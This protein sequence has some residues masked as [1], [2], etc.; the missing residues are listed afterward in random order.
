MGLRMNTTSQKSINGQTDSAE[1]QIHPK[2]TELNKML[3]KSASMSQIMAL[4]AFFSITTNNRLLL[5]ANAIDWT[6]FEKH[7]SKHYSEGV[8][9]NNLP[10]RLMVGLHILKYL[11]DL[12]DERVVQAWKEN[13]AYRLFTGWEGESTNN[14]PCDPSSLCKFRKRMGYEGMH[15]IFQM[16]LQLH[17]QYNSEILLISIITVD[18]SV[19]EKY[20]AF[21]T[22]HKLIYDAL[23]MLLRLAAIKDI[24]INISVLIDAKVM[25]KN[26]NFK[27]GKNALVVKDDILEKLRAHANKV[28]NKIFRN[29][30]ANTRK[31]YK[32]QLAIYKKAINQKKDDKNKV[33]SVFEPAVR[34]IAKGK[35][36]KKFEF[37]SKISIAID[38]YS[39]VILAIINHSDNPYDGNT[40]EYLIAKIIKLMPDVELKIINADLGFRRKNKKYIEGVLL[41]TPAS[42][43]D[44]NLSETDIEMIKKLIKKRGSIEPVIGHMKDSHRLGR[45]YLRGIV[46][47]EINAT[48][49]AA[50]Y[51]FQ[52]FIQHVLK[53]KLSPKKVKN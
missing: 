13:I 17:I 21:P 26:I 2:T 22:D 53:P 40:S 30:S 28:Y 16:S 35:P 9:R 1:I 36:H 49:S 19:Q 11:D 14:F 7:M 47:D 34:C 44:K 48:L 45:N 20:T 15:L 27:K 24:K 12:S 10:I 46:G 18:T 5:L 4:A 39:G 6:F 41:V 37:G 23:I 51:N 42:I 33:Y 52:K 32:S 29:L 38:Y 50:G 25:V 31:E 43:N 3:S 8:G